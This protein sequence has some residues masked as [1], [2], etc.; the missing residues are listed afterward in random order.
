MQRAPC[1][2]QAADRAEHQ[3]ERQREQEGVA[4]PAPL[5]PPDDETQ[6]E[7]CDLREHLALLKCLQRHDARRNTERLIAHV[8]NFREQEGISRTRNLDAD[9]AES[10]GLG[11]CARGRRGECQLTACR[12][13]SSDNPRNVTGPAGFSAKHHYPIC[14]HACCN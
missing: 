1:D 2:E 4:I 8:E 3:R 9:G 6:N 10:G 11:R 7:R 12:S 5:P 14:V 13:A